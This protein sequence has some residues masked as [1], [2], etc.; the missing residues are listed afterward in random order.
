MDANKKR[1]RE[2]KDRK[3]AAND[4]DGA[5]VVIVRILWFLVKLAAGAAATVLLV[6]LIAGILFSVC[7]FVNVQIPQCL[8]G[9]AFFQNNNTLNPYNLTELRGGYDKI[10]LGVV[11]HVAR[12]KVRVTR[13]RGT[14]KHLVIG[15]G[16]LCVGLCGHDFFAKQLYV[17]E[18]FLDTRRR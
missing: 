15:I 8:I 11:F 2:Y 4:R 1:L 6:A 17:Y 9:F 13:K 18:K 16:E 12:D 14:E 5:P 3:R 10:G 7:V